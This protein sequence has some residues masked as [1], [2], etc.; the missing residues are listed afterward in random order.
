MYRFCFLP[1]VHKLRGRTKGGR[2]K[3]HCPL[4]H[5]PH[6]QSLTVIFFHTNA[7]KSSDRGSFQGESSKRL[8][9]LKLQSLNGDKA[10]SY[11][12]S[13]L[14][15]EGLGTILKADDTGGVGTNSV[16]PGRPQPCIS[17]FPAVVKFRLR[18]AELSLGAGEELSS[19]MTTVSSTSMT[20][21]GDA[22]A[23]V[24]TEA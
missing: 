22:G 11:P 19:M 14:S 23:V 4:P 9:S 17:L 6:A 21:A 1:K 16:S 8:S 13:V 5:L 24:T 20:D 3:G 15:A 7:G 10:D 18:W 12:V 2:R